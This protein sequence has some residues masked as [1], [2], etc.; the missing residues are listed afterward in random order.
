[1]ATTPVKGGGPFYPQHGMNQQTPATQHLITGAA[2]GAYSPV[3]SST[4]PRRKKKAT[5]TRRARS[6][7][8]ASKKRRASSSARSPSRLVKGSAAAKKRMAQLR[9]MRK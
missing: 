3:R 9:K 5:T 1:M 4:A 2:G 6:S 8:G 7:G